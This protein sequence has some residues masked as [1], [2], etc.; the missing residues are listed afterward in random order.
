MC[1]CPLHPCV[2][3]SLLPSLLPPSLPP[4]FCLLPLFLLSQWLTPVLSSPPPS[5]IT[6]YPHIQH[7]VDYCSNPFLPT[8]LLLL[9]LSLLT[10]AIAVV[11]SSTIGACAFSL[12]SPR[13]PQKIVT[14]V[15]VYTKSPPLSSVHHHAFSL[16]GA[17]RAYTEA[18]QVI[19]LLIFV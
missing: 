5:P 18:V 17:N 3:P 11:G 6:S 9:S 7:G 1:P 2:P 8:F 19:V 15:D 4:Y 13:R 10:Q 16:L 12:S 14:Q